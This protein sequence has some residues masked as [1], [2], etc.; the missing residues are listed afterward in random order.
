MKTL[1]AGFGCRYAGKVPAQVLQRLMRHADI[2]TTMGYY[3]N[4]DDAVMDAVLGGK[5]NTS[6]NTGGPEAADA[7]AAGGATGVV[8]ND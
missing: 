4:V 7:E 8:D 5:R 3:A 2:K 1:R 6:R